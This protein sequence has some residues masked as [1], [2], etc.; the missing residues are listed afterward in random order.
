MQ[1]RPSGCWRS[2]R[3]GCRHDPPWPA[4]KRIVGFLSLLRAASMTLADL[5]RSRPGWWIDR[6]RDR[7]RAPLLLG[8]VL[9]AVSACSPDYSPDTYATRAVQQANKVEQGVVVGVRN[10]GVTAEGYDRCRQRSRRRR[11]ARIADAG[12]CRWGARHDR[13]R[14]DGRTGRHGGRAHDRRHHRLRVYREKIQRRSSVGDPA[15]CH[16]ARSGAKSACHYR[17]SGPRG[18]GLYGRDRAGRPRRF[19]KGKVAGTEKPAEA[20]ANPPPASTQTPPPGGEAAGKPPTSLAPPAPEPASVAGQG[21]AT[22]GPSTAESQPH[23]P[24][25][26]P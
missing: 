17:Q 15:R 7:I 25:Q 20:P 12:Q 21:A 10:V 9:A 24:A 26:S 18:A 22:S 1:A 19:G 5:T 3:R 14:A 6:R 4:L 23:P 13:R 2:Q 11:P 8:F 16:P